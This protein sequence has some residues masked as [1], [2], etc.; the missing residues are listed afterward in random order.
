MS[1]CKCTM[2]ISVNGD[3]CR[4]C[5][6]QT[7]I[8][9]LIETLDEDRAERDA[10]LAKVEELEADGPVAVYAHSVKEFRQQR[11]HLAALLRLTK[12]ID[13][14]GLDLDEW[15]DRVDSA[16]SSITKEPT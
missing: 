14:A 13:W 2:A 9:H 15:S 11:D 7:Y 8:D 5:Q 10:A 6:P 1:K 4:Y 3:G 16:L 12:A